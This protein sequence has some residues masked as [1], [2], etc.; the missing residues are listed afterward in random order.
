MDPFTAHQITTLRTA[1]NAGTA[2][3]DQM[4]AGDEFLGA[5][6]AAEAAG[7]PRS[8]FG[9]NVFITAYLSRL[10]T[11]FP[12]GVITDRDGKLIIE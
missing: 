8:T 4:K 3:V 2:A 1:M 9:Y 7:Y 6:P 11:R 12:K 5:M 10:D